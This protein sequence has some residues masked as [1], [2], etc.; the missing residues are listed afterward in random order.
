[1]LGNSGGCLGDL[2]WAEFWPKP[3]SPL[4][5][6]P[7][8]MGYRDTLALQSAPLPGPELWPRCVALAVPTAYRDSE[9]VPGRRI[10]NSPAQ[11]DCKAMLDDVNP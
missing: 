5:P 9:D 8:R 11:I 4:I 3:P 7:P 10:E 1:M 6:G 2:V